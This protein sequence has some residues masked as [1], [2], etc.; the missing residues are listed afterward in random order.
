[1]FQ[2][3]WGPCLFEAGYRTEH[4]DTFHKKKSVKKWEDVGQKTIC[5]VGVYT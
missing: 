4:F 2:N 1:M 5:K 3:P